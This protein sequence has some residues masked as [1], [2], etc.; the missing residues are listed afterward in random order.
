MTVDNLDSARPHIGRIYD[1]ILGGHHNFEVDRSAAAEMLKIVPRYPELARLNRWFLQLIA[2]RWA[3]AKVQ[4]LLDLGS[5]LP[6]QGHFNEHL[7]NARILFSD[8]D[9]LSVSYGQKILQDC[10]HQRYVQVDLLQPEPLLKNAEEFFGKGAQMAI[11]FIGISYLLPDHVVQQIAQFT[12]GMCAPGSE[13]AVS[14]GELSKRDTESATKLD[15]AAQV[16]RLIRAPLYLRTPSELAQLLLPWRV[17][18]QNRLEE[19]LDM[20]GFLPLK[21]QNTNAL[22]VD[23]YGVI[24]TR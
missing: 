9:E 1:F 18:E 10:A 15:F 21:S 7:P 20:K 2:M 8:K 22:D 16:S 12:H 17:V 13:L 11:G 5:G 19:W 23:I 4:N 6:T 3:E 24:A 14:G